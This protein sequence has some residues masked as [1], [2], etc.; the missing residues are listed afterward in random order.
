MQRLQVILRSYKLQNKTDSSDVNFPLM[1]NAVTSEETRPSE[2]LP[3]SPK[4][5]RLFEMEHL[6]M[7]YVHYMSRK[8]EVLW[9][10]ELMDQLPIVNLRGRHAWTPALGRNGSRNS[11][12]S[13]VNSKE[14][15]ETA[16]Q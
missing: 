4:L 9:I 2:T 14:E 16:N 8:K 5:K 15:N 13:Q 7:K 6:L 10:G 3:Y 12:T 11:I 1:S